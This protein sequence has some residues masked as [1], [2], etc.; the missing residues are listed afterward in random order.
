MMGGG[1]E[2]PI[3]K[4]SLRTYLVVSAPSGEVLNV[5]EVKNVPLIVQNEECV[6]EMSSFDQGPLHT[7]VYLAR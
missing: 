5:R 1:A 6:H 2:S 7:S 3:E 4:T